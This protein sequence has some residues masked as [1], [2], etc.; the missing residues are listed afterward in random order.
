MFLLKVVNII[1]SHIVQIE[2]FQRLVDDEHL[3]LP[4]DKLVWIGVRH[5]EEGGYRWPS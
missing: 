2:D 1:E 5:T 3:V 4:T